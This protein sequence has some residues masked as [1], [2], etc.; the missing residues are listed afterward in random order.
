METARALAQ[1]M[2]QG[3]RPERT[4]VLGGWDGEEYGM[5]GSTEWA[6]EFG[7]QLRKNAVTY[8]DLDS[9]GA[10]S[11]FYA[12]GVP[13]LDGLLYDVAKEVEEPRT[14]GQSVYADW[15]ARSGH[16]VPPVDRLGGGFDYEVWIDHLGVPTIQMSFDYAGSGNY[17][18][19]Y[20]DLYFMEHWGDPGYLHHAAAARL[21]GIASL[22][23]ANADILPFQYSSYAS[24][25]SGYLDRLNARQVELYGEVMVNFEREMVQAQAWQAAKLP[26]EGAA[27]AIL[28]PIRPSVRFGWTGGF[29]QRTAYQ[30]EGHDAAR[31][32]R[33]AMVQ[34]YDLRAGAVHGLWRA[35]PIGFGRLTGRGRL[36]ESA[37]L[38]SAAPQFADHRYQH[39]A[40]RLLKDIPE[41]FLPPVLAA[42]GYEGHRH[43]HVLLELWTVPLPAL[44]ELVHAAAHRHHQP[45]AFVELVQQCFRHLWRSRGDHDRLEGRTP[46]TN[47]PSPMCTDTLLSPGLFNTPAACSASSA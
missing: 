12:A 13:S 22:R 18:S 17:H 47:V 11:Y 45:P 19:T 8:L 7:Q 37:Q 16:P 36:V 26:T 40:R 6:E 27:E 30:Q 31:V 46:A 24:E 29:R 4:I 9:A 34:A 41:I 2:Q 42:Q 33:P 20:D 32:A 43:Q 15:A 3:W 10:G 21:A 35:V 1:L 23:L 44:Q 14:P 38:S 28:L 25:V 39:G 5:L